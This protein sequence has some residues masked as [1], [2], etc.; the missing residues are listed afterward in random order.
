[1]IDDELSCLSLRNTLD[2]YIMM[3]AGA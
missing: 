1:M 3:N 2:K